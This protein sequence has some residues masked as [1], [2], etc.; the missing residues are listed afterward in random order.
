MVDV[1]VV[2]VE[3]FAAAE[4]VGSDC[5]DFEGVPWLE[6]S[7]EPLDDVLEG[8][9]ESVVVAV[10][11]MVKVEE[12]SAVATTTTTEAGEASLEDVD[13]FSDVS[14]ETSWL[15]VF[16]ECADCVDCFVGRS[17]DSVWDS[18]VEVTV[19]VKDGADTEPSELPATETKSARAPEVSTE[20][21]DVARERAGWEVE[22]TEEDKGKEEEDIRESEMGISG[23]GE[24]DD[25]TRDVE[26]MGSP[27][28][29]GVM[30]ERE[31]PEEE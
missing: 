4:A 16:V 24:M 5:V 20:D 30:D 23:V 1:G 11:V 14:F 12:D 6:P 10:G 9:G 27:V 29:I 21:D 19:L 22:S 18:E 31:D 2:F 3:S 8:V 17:V 26:K 13:V 28:E 15:L 7:L 25:V